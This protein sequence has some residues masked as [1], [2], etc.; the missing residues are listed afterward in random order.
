MAKY[1]AETNYKK[2]KSRVKIM[3]FVRDQ[4]LDIY[5]EWSK[6]LAKSKLSRSCIIYCKIS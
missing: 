6:T 3:N 4:G 2:A 5:M 1:S